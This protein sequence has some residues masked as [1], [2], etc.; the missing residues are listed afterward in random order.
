MLTH[1]TVPWSLEL[2]TLASR[3]GDLVAVDD[4]QSTM[5]YAE[6]N[7]RAHG[8]ARVLHAQGVQAGDCIGIYLP[9]GIPAVWA[10]YGT[11]ISA[12]CVVHLNAAYTREEIQWSHQ[13][14]PMRIIVTDR[15]HAE[16][17]QGLG[18]TLIL[19]DE[20]PPWDCP[21]VL[22]A[23]PVEA[24]AR[25]IYSSGTTGRPKALVY[26]QGRRWLAA[27]MLRAEL[28]FTPGPGSRILLMTPY[29]HGASMQAR[30]WLD[31]GGT[32][33]L[34][35]GVNVEVV[36]RELEGEGL[37]AIFA[38][39]TVLA[40]LVSAFE[41]ARFPNVRCIFTG[42]QTLTAALYQRAR[43]IFGAK[44]RVTYGKSENF[45]PITVLE[46]A[47]TDASF[48][49][50]GQEG[51]CL[52][53]PA[54]GVQLRING[55]GE[56]ELRSHHMYSGHVDAA[57]FHP[58]D[59][60]G[61]HRTGDLGQIDARGRLW[62][63]GRTADVIKSGGY[64]IYPDEIEAALAG[65]PGCQDICVVAIP[66]DYWGE[67]I[68]AVAET[69]DVDWA[70]R[71]RQHLATLARYKHPR[72]FVQVQTLPRNPQGKLSRRAVRDQILSQ[73]RLVDG[74]YPVLQPL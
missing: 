1:E 43:Q 50:R 45:N 27:L 38:P 67:V 49:E 26:D 23:V 21:A 7:A 5:T 60:D 17:V 14:T 52:G 30:A 55:Q 73:Y 35:N 22:P 59:A 58:R 34:L 46:P 4:G 39:P 70:D 16:R 71:A 48:D 31:N 62:L 18:A 74:A 47:D 40:K 68:V 72:A 10:D 25:V 11:T 51:A 20:V 65:T 28:P 57:G 41:G 44:L 33:V 3:Y 13:L 54:P 2:H 66:S 32:A 15:D 63:L 56:I 24:W 37:D 53:W 64:K 9:N 6:L 61:W 19:C 69:T 42:T 29:V 8:L 36:R 12:G